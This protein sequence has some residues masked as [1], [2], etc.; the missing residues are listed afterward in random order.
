MKPT[1]FTC[2]FLACAAQLIFAGGVSAATQ[3]ARL[4]ILSEPTIPAE[5]SPFSPMAIM[6]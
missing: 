6:S 4:A 2:T 5:V 3:T 1:A